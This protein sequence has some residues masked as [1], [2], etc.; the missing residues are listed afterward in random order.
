MEKTCEEYME[1]IE[2]RVLNLDEC[3]RISEID[4]QQYIKNAWRLVKGQ[5][6]L[7]KIDYMEMD[8]PDG[9][10]RYRNE[11]E[12]T[13]KMDGIAFGAF[14]E[15]GKLIGFASLKHNQFGNISKYILLDSIFVSNEARGKGIGKHLFNLC[16]LQGKSWGMD[17]IYICA[18]SAEE[19]IAFYKNIGC[20]E[21]L[22]INKELY[23]QDIR[24]L[25]LE[26]EL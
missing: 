16:S 4:P 25:Q 5:R 11:L 7:V 13:I 26:Y 3:D 10:E 6:V 14:A 15:S 18:G 20:I 8:W 12:K 1:N 21:A 19:T 22:E 2:Y 17:K 24:D 23:E 9:Y